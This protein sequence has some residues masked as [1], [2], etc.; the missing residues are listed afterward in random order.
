MISV[1]ELLCNI[2]E[3]LNDDEAHRLLEL[4]Q[5]LQNN[6]EFSPTISRLASDPTFKV[7]SKIHGNFRP[8]KPIKGKGIPASQLLVEDRR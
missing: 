6:H 7:P 2:I 1:K 8:V 5:N 3:S 4:A